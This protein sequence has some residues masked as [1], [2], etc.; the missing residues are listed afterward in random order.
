MPHSYTYAFTSSGNHAVLL[1]AN[2]SPTGLRSPCHFG[3]SI[4]PDL[5]IFPPGKKIP[6]RHSVVLQ[7]PQKWEVMSLPESAVLVNC[8]GVPAGD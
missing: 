7:S 2:S 4:I 6:L 3:S 5:T 8:L 1:S